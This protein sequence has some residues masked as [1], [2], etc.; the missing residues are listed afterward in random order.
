[1]FHLKSVLSQVLD[2]ALVVFAAFVT[3]DVRDLIDLANRTN[4]AAILFKILGSLGYQ[5]D[6]LGLVNSGL[7]DT[8]LKKAGIARTEKALVRVQCTYVATANLN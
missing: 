6:P 4:A 8:E 7:T 5:N 3:R 1:M 2:S